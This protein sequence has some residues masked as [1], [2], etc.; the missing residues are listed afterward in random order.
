MAVRKLDGVETHQHGCTQ[1]ARGRD[2]PRWLYASC[3][4]QRQTKKAK[5][6]LDGVETRR[7]G[8]R[9]AAWVEKS[10]RR[11]K[12]AVRKLHMVEA[13]QDGC[14]GLRIAIFACL[15]PVHL[16]YS[17]LGPSLPRATCIQP[18]WSVSTP[19]SLRAAILITLYTVQL[20]CSQMCVVVRLYPVGIEY[21]HHG[22]SLPHAACVQP[23]WSVSTSCSLRKA[24]LVSLYIA[25]LAYSH[26][27]PSLPRAAC[28]QP[29]WSVFTPCSLR[30]AILVHLNP[31]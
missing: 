2:G 1:A 20:A 26:L 12:M 13:V 30:T 18:S 31:I 10:A 6:K 7:D 9:Q 11:T 16:T 27:G 29:C 22:P 14:S 3:T 24:I 25:Q 5:H 4:G 15:Y 19:C 23:S 8:Y 17:H 28:V 21:S